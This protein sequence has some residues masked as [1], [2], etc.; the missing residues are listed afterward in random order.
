MSVL[1]L[2]AVPTGSSEGLSKAIA[3]LDSWGFDIG[4]VRVSIWTALVS[5]IIIAALVLFARYA[6][7]LA[8]RL[9]GRFSGLDVAQ[10][11]LGEK[12]I[13][14]AIWAAAFFVGLDLLGINLTALTVFS[15]A[16]GLAV[17]FG[18]QRPSAT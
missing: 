14:L 3:V 10:R 13:S 12:L 9:L 7:R 11:S 1:A 16:F 4:S 8:A 15:G 6:S 5:L 18:L 2:A 17:G